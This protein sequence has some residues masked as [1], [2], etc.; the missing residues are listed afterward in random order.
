[1]NIRRFLHRDIENLLTS[2]KNEAW[3]LRG[4]AYGNAF[5]CRMMQ[6]NPDMSDDAL[7]IAK[8]AEAEFLKIGQSRVSVDEAVCGYGG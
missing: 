7:S 3:R 8:W 2:K 4:Y 6:D 1:M 5:A